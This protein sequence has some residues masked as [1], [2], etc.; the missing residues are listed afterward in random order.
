MWVN[1]VHPLSVH[2]SP[3]SC[4]SF[5]FRYNF[6]SSTKIFPSWVIMRNGLPSNKFVSY[7]VFR[8]V[9]GL[10]CKMLQCLFSS[11]CC[12]EEV[13]RGSQ[14]HLHW[15]AWH[16]SFFCGFFSQRF[17]IRIVGCTKKGKNW[18]ALMGWYVKSVCM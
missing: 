18:N 9:Q 1:I 10:L 2:N 7:C 8:N 3:F 13:F 15:R 5:F 12:G 4:L 17:L 11:M 6:L 14:S 16:Q